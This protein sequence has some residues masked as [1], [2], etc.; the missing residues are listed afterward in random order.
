MAGKKIN[1]MIIIGYSKVKKMRSMRYRYLSKSIFVNCKG[2]NESFEGIN[3]RGAHFSRSSFNNALFKNCDF[4][5]TT[6]KKCKFKN[7]IFMDCVFQGCKFKNCDFAGGDLQY[8]A[9]V[10]TNIKECKG[11]ELGETTEMLN[12]YPKMEYSEEL[13]SVLESLKNNKDLLK[14]KVLWIS[15]KKPNHLNLYLL[16]RKN[17]EAQIVDY[18]KCLTEKEKKRLITYGCCSMGL[19][20]FKK[21]SI[22]S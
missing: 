15:S 13:M 11:I 16:L 4:W 20:K 12:Q 7:A 22:L 8:S 10:N 1:R 19:H 14:T 17:N 21:S 6:F 2:D 5:G 9:I 3:F 18:L